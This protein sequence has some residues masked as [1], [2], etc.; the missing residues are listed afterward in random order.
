MDFYQTIEFEVNKL[1]FKRDDLE[2]SFWHRI[3]DSQIWVVFLGG[4]GNCEHFFKTPSKFRWQGLLV[5]VQ[6]QGGK[7]ALCTDV[8]YIRERARGGAIC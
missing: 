4:N 7:P 2:P 5:I 3:W 6:K 8:K 1:D